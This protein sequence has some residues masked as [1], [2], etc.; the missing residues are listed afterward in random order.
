[1]NRRSVLRGLVA[2]GGSAALAACIRASDDEPIPTG[3][4][5]NRPDRQHA[6]NDR[7]RQ[8][9]H[10][11][12][13]PPYHHV[14]LEFTY[15]G[16]TPAADRSDLEEALT[17]LETAYEASH[18]GLLFTIGYAP[19]YFDRFDVSLETVDLPHPAPLVPGENVATSE[20]DIFLHLASDRP[21]AVLGAEEALLETG[22]A[23]DV[24]VTR[25]DGLL[26]VDER[27]TGFFGAGLPKEH[28]HRLQGIP[29]EPIHEEAPFFMDFRA[30]FRENQAPEDRVT[31]QEGRFAGGC[32]QHVETI[33]LTLGQW[34]QR[35]H[36]AQVDRF[37]SPDVDPDAVG[38]AGLGIEDRSPVEAK[39]P[40]ELVTTAREQGVV[41]HAE[42][43]AHLREDGR[44]PILRRDVN[45][46]D[47]ME[48]GIIFVSLQ[49]AVEDFERL[50][51]A[52]AG[53][54]LIGEGGVAEEENNGIRQYINPR[55]RAN[56]LVPP[57]TD[58]SLPT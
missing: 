56:F 18:R 28:N 46:D 30:G 53:T 44:P 57:R 33:N 55:K 16:S 3:D 34:F 7:L 19:R 36:E 26:E 37:F 9:E 45:S 6:W 47:N 50:R 22:E 25:V 2:A 43:M 23:N 58:R 52:M 13:L 35:P 14:F 54:D 11:N 41:G 8:D 27:R 29:G 20:A 51:L 32:T 38:P 39:T 15:T 48:A 21:E 49:R 10:G 40:E 42:K 17:D 1:M 4:P 5:T 31:I 24:S 12:Y